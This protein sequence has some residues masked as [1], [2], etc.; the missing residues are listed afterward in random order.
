MSKL[1]DFIIMTCSFFCVFPHIYNLSV[2]IK[3]GGVGLIKMYFQ[4]QSDAIQIYEL[5]RLQQETLS[6]HEN[7][8]RLVDHQLLTI[9][10]KQ[11]K[12]ALLREVV[13]PV[14]IRYLIS[15]KEQEFLL[16]IIQSKFFYE[17]HEE[18]IQILHMV[19]SI[20]EGERTDIPQKQFSKSRERLVEEALEELLTEERDFTFESFIQFRLRE[21]CQR[22]QYYVG[23]GIDEYKLEQE[24]QVYIEQ[25]RQTIRQQTHYMSCVYVVHEGSD[26]FKLYDHSLLEL[27]DTQREF[28]SANAS[29]TPKTL[30]IDQ[31][32]VAPLVGMAPSAVYVYTNDP[33]EG[34]I[35]LLRTIFQERVVLYSL[36]DFFS[37]CTNY[38]QEEVDF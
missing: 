31:R 13:I 4:N 9:D 21:Y 30:Y 37:V 34:S 35:Q 18:Q 8:F 27:N 11:T 29:T 5:L 12:A 25:L 10:A 6:V 1:C 22:L 24:Y 7:C 38:A 20:L 14:F 19:Q 2:S 23:V 17:E 33:T 26:R 36:A 32:V 3:K 15:F 28:F 16:S